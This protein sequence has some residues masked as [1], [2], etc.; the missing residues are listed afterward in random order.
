MHGPWYPNTAIYGLVV[1]LCI[2]CSRHIEWRKPFLTPCREIAETVWTRRYVAVQW[3]R[4]SKQL[5]AAQ[6]EICGL[7]QEIARMTATNE[8]GRPLGVSQE[9]QQGAVTPCLPNTAKI[10]SATSNSAVSAQ[11]CD[12]TPAAGNRPFDKADIALQH[13]SNPSK[14]GV[15]AA[16][17]GAVPGLSHESAS[18][19]PGLLL[20]NSKT[21]V[22]AKDFDSEVSVPSSGQD[23]TNLLPMPADVAVG[24]ANQVPPVS[25]GDEYASVRSVLAD[26][27]NDPTDGSNG[28]LAKLARHK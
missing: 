20:N 21:A 3:A 17:S 13:R 18:Q 10:S 22:L 19:P 24:I 15:G 11:R 16:L 2:L 8:A 23:V 26:I 7:K 27:S 25:P 9:A 28:R 14:V 6:S 5:K 12:I 1:K 4:D